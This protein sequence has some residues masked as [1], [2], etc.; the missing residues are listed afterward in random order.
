MLQKCVS[1]LLILWLAGTLTTQVGIQ[2]QSKPLKIVASF[3]ILEDVV[4]NIAGDNAEISALIPAGVDPHTF[5]PSP[6]DI[7]IITEAD[8]VFI[9]GVNFEE[10]LMEAIQNAGTSTN[11]VVASSCVPILPIT[12]GDAIETTTPPEPAATAEHIDS[13]IAQ[14]CAVHETELEQLNSDNGV[15]NTQ[16]T[17]KVQPVGALYSITC[18]SYN[19]SAEVHEGGCDPHVWTDPQNVIYWSLMIRDTLIELDPDNAPAYTTNASA[20]ITQLEQLTHDFIVPTLNSIPETD[21][22]LVT[23][24]DTLGY[25]ANAF[26]YSIVGTIIPGASTTTE[27]SAADIAAL[28]DTLKQEHVAAVFAESTVNARVAEQVAAES[29]A[30]FY[31]LLSDSLSVDD[32]SGATYLDY[33]RYNVTTIVKALGGNLPAVNP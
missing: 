16:I 24:H 22:I 30:Q 7:T 15:S 21:R 14:H 25:M 2:A 9:N 31:S 8:V 28:I 4:R 29:G 27:P 10:R 32:N 17:G 13:I 26:D 1:L 5:S 20:Y 3:S 23:N 33:M 18:G 6:R 12:A 19:E 11:I